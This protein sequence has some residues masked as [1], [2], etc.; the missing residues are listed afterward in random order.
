MIIP[1]TML[2]GDVLRGIVEEFVLREGTE[3]GYGTTVGSESAPAHTLETKVAQVMKQLAAGD[4][5]VVYDQGS[6]SC[7]LVTKGSKAF[8]AAAA[9]DGGEEG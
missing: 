5:V 3:Y 4:V 1:Y 6:E 9:N 2:S 7:D 8:V